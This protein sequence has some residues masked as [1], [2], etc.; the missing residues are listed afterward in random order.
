GCPIEGCDRP[1]AWTHA[2]HTTAWA[3]GGHTNLADGISPCAYHHRL[4]HSTKWTATRLP[5]GKIRL[6]RTTRS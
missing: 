3:D 5:N 1:S 4:L 6:R 2:H